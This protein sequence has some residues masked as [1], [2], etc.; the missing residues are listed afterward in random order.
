MP[1]LFWVAAVFPWAHGVF[2]LILASGL[3][4]SLPGIYLWVGLAIWGF[5]LLLPCALVAT[6]GL[7][8]QWKRLPPGKRLSAALLVLAGI[9]FD[10]W[11]STGLDMFF[12]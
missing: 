12:T 11:A 1:T 5:M 6:A 8:L 2:V 7:V 4:F 9:G 3:L 10:Y